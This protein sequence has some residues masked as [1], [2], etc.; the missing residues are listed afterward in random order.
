MDPQL[1]SQLVQFLAPFLPYLLKG[2]KL[3]E[4]EA[5]KKLGE[6]AGEQGF[7]QA[8]AL[9]EKLRPKVEARPAALEAAQDAAA[10][11][12]DE[13]ALAALRLQLKKLLAEDDSLAQELARLLAQSRPA[14]QTVIA[15]GDRSV[16]IGG[17]VSGSVI[18]TGDQNVVQQGKY[19]V[20]IGQ[21]SGQVTG[22]AI[23]DHAKAEVTVP[24]IQKEAVRQVVTRYTDIACP[25]RVWVQ[26]PRIPVVVRLTMRSPIHSDAI[27]ELELQTQ[28]PVRVRIEAPAFDVLNE[29]EQE[30][31]VLPDYDSPP[32][33]FDL[34]PRR[35][36]PARINFDFFQEGNPIGTTSL[37]VEVTEH[38]V[39]HEA[40][41]G[42]RQRLRFEPSA[43][44]PDL[45]LYI[46]F[47]RFREQPAL[48]FTLIRA[49]Q[50]GRTFHP[51]PL[52]S[53]PAAHTARL[54]EHLTVL[55]E[56]LDPTANLVLG[57][58]RLLPPEDIERRL[59]HFGHNLWKYLIPD[60]LKAV[61]AKERS[62]WQDKTL[63][64]VSDE[65]YIPWELVWPYEQGEWQDDAPWC[66]TLRLTR[67]L[68]RDFQGN[69][70]E[71]P[72]TQILFRNIACLAPTD[73]GLPFAQ[74]E[75]KFL[76]TLIARH[77]L[78]NTSPK[79]YTWTEV[80]ELLERGVYHWLHVAAHGNFYPPTPESDSAIW[81][82]EKRPLTPD[83]IVGPDIEGHINQWRPGFVFNACHSGRQGWAL[84][85]LGGWANRL[86]SS[87]AGL[88]IAPMWT[89]TDGQA[90][91]FAQ[92]FYDELLK[93]N[94][95]S[96]SVRKARLATRM[97]GD[98]TWLAYTVYA[99]PN[100]CIRQ[101]V[102][103]ADEP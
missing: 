74:K 27:E 101:S 3:A 39:N 57:Q 18:V 95:V 98:P 82:Q 72:P 91:V 41:Q 4:Q 25:R 76:E 99:H 93:G 34:R 47:E 56:Q 17:S 21:V 59:K 102:Q 38:Q 26:T 36:G 65:P 75:K 30:T 83:S 29:P 52:Q 60:D 70:H 54:Y 15:S 67:W 33:V 63:L 8:K 20:N 45:M 50:V 89:V 46:S 53:D 14:G 88:F 10:H 7:E 23:G 66:I 32:L 94:I 43:T 80:M 62:S 1:P 97:A 96:D 58:K 5:A 40:D 81:L 64:I 78:V 24:G 55:T 100:A 90:F 12:D 16:A 44:S 42:S 6:K 87:G 71:A 68:R 49:G 84:T 51:V 61:Y 31:T 79:K 9:W 13:D 92:T 77:G 73:S 19:N 103:L 11:P 2:L 86:I 48:V 28:V 22:V 37:P 35:V 85:N 69:G